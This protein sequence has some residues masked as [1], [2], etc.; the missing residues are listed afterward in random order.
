MADTPEVGGLYID[1]QLVTMESLSFREQR[2][3]RELVREIAPNGDL[4]EAQEMDIVPAIVCVVHRRTNPDYSLD[5]ALD[6][7]EEQL[8]PPSNGKGTSKRPSKRAASST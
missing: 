3:V 1:G 8:A 4:D 6:V 5:E 2:Q 7:T